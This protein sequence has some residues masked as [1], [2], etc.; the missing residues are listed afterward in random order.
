MIPKKSRLP[1]AE[2]RSAAYRTVKTPYFLLKAKHS[3]DG[4]VKIG[5]VVGKSVHKNAT[6][7]NFWKR[8]AKQVILEKGKGSEN[9]FL[10]VISPKV[11]G[12]TKKQFQSELIKAVRMVK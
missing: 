7:R 4:S 8:Q 5:V 2:F 12:L 10:M 1:R 3:P 9:D 11:N 6:E